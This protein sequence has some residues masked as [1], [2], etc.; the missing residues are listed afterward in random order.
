MKSDIL[1]NSTTKK[2]INSFVASP[3]HALL[4][5]GKPNSGKGYLAKQIAEELVGEDKND[6]SILTLEGS[7]EATIEAIRNLHAFL[8]LR[9][10]GRQIIRR[11]VIIEDLDYFGPEAQ[12]TLLKVL[13][14][15]PVDT[16]I[17]STVSNPTFLLPTVKSRTVCIML[18]PVTLGQTTTYFKDKN[19]KSVNEA[20]LLSD[21]LPALLI[22]LMADQS[23]DSHPLVRSIEKAKE[24]LAMKTYD[25]LLRVEE[26]SKLDI[27]EQL[28][29]VSALQKLLRASILHGKNALSQDQ[30]TARSRQLES[31]QDASKHLKAHTQPKAVFSNLFISL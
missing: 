26:I 10:S 14:E 13:E 2:E 21:G 20:F 16:V 28:N 1:I 3:M 4:I 29:L 11:V 30:K 17:I 12:N 23:T 25:R 7:K 8:K 18:R 24:I 19:N 5:E 31:L 27:A 22:S 15:P 6:A 9:V